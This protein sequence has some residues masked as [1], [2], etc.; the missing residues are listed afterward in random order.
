MKWRE[1]KKQ[2]K[3]EYEILLQQS[4]PFM[5]ETT[6]TKKKKNNNN[7][8]A[9]RTFDENMILSIVFNVWRVCEFKVE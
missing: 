3:H 4:T 8:K 2:N 6:T 9:E 7:S 1:N 5:H